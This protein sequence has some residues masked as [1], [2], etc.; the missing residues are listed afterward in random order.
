MGRKKLEMSNRMVI[1][2]VPFQDAAGTSSML[3]SPNELKSYFRQ[4]IADFKDGEWTTY[5][6]PSRPPEERVGTYY[7]TLTES[8]VVYILTFRQTPEMKKRHWL[9]NA[10]EGSGYEPS[11]GTF[12]SYNCEYV[13]YVDETN[14]IIQRLTSILLRP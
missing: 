7:K 3:S 4:E 10:I 13:A 8:P 14:N 6:F 2:H 1:V 5:V 12:D 9:G 11:S